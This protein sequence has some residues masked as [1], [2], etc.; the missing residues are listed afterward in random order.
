MNRLVCIELQHVLYH[1]IQY[2]D[3]INDYNQETNSKQRTVDVMLYPNR[4]SSTFSRQYAL[5]H[6]RESFRVKIWSSTAYAVTTQHHPQ[7]KT[8]IIQAVNSTIST[9]KLSIF[10]LRRQSTDIIKCSSRKCT[11][12]WKISRGY[13]TTR[14][15]LF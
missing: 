11:W 5:K 10:P 1:Y 2:Y 6:L 15:T 14:S 4:A 3:R 13:H 7:H 8:K 9:L 12:V